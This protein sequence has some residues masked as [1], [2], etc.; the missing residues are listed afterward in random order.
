MKTKSVTTLETIGLLAWSQSRRQGL[1]R[2]AFSWRHFD[3]VPARDGRTDRQTDIPTVAN[4]VLYIAS[5][6]D[7]L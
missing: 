7:S 3:T 6:A 2:L 1:A 5:Y 4:T